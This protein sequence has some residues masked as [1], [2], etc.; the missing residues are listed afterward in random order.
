MEEDNKYL[1]I[2]QKFISIE[3]IEKFYSLRD[4]MIKAEAEIFRLEQELAEKLDNKP[5]YTGS[6][7]YSVTMTLT[8]DV[9][10]KSSELN[11]APQSIEKKS[12]SYIIDFIDNGYDKLIDRMYNRFTTVLQEACNELVPKQKESDDGDIPPNTRN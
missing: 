2:V 1:D 10:I 6:V 4:K 7:P 5:K 9:S 8:T 3:E 12:Q 11:H